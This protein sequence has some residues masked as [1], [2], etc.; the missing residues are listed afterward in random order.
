MPRDGEGNFRAL[1]VLEGG[2]GFGTLSACRRELLDVPSWGQGL[3]RLSSG[4]GGAL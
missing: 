2:H 1:F 4:A 3:V